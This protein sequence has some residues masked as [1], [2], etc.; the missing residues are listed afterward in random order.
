[1][2]LCD[3]IYSGLFWVSGMSISY[4]YFI[5]LASWREILNFYKTL[6]FSAGAELYHQ[7]RLWASEDMQSRAQN[8]I[9]ESCNQLDDLRGQ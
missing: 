1:M 7:A 8:F 2:Y 3:Q 6:F 9:M 4:A 5:V